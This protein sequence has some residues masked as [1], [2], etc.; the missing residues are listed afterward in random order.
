MGIRLVCPNGHRL[1]VKDKYAGKT[2]YCPHCQAKVR[3]PVLEAISEDDIFQLLNT[4]AHDAE[5]ED[6]SDKS[7]LDDPE[8]NASGSNSELSLLGSGILRPMKVCPQCEK[9]TSF[10]F[11][12]CPRCGTVL[13]VS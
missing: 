12:N 13:A 3:V 7:V 2:G 6:I 9:R 1:N 8:P 10:T 5:Q 4:S 11:T